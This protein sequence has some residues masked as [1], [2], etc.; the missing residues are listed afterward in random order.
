[1]TDKLENDARVESAFETLPP[2]FDKFKVVYR[3]EILPTLQAREGDR[4]AAAEKAK[5]FTVIAAAVGLIIALGGIFL[6]KSPFFAF[7]GVIAG[8]G[9][10]TYGRSGL[11][12]IKREAKLL[13]VETA[14][15]GF[16]L[17]YD[18]EPQRPLVLSRFSNLGLIPSWDREKFEDQLLGKRGTTDFE[19]FEAHLESRR[20]TTD[21]KGRS[22]TEWVTVF[23]GQCL[24]VNFHKPFNGQTKVYRDLGLFNFF[25]K[26]GNSFSSKKLERVRLE[27]PKFEKAFE[28]FS[29]DQVE[30]R[31]LL[32]PDFMERLLELERIFE[33][34]KLRCA[35]SGGELFVCVEGG[36]LF[37]P[38]SMFTPLDNPD[39]MR[40]LMQDFLAVFKLIDSVSDRA[41]R[42]PPEIEKPPQSDGDTPWR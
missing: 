39:R 13:I 29:D 42:A 4:L 10:H 19:F 17:E 41:G 20:T 35:F 15:Q 7:L 37:E 31:F 9:I 6:T 3:D 32:T 21:S 16:D 26:M 14:A 1:M 24:V 18:P 8:F 12:D 2:E 38:G 22:R 30:S 27:D 11:N 5:N 25:T 23:Q 40:D 34:G 36:D 28:V 33:G